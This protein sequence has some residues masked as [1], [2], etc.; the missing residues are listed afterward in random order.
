MTVKY[1]INELKKKAKCICNKIK[2]L[3]LVQ[4]AL[5]RFRVEDAVAD[6]TFY[7]NE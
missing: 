3:N 1:I 5:S 2:S 7:F 4:K 6:L